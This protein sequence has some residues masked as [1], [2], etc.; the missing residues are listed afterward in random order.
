M[1]HVLSHPGP[2]R[3]GDQ[4]RAINR[5]TLA[6]ALGVVAVI[7]IASSFAIN[8]ISLVESTQVKARVLAENAGA[9][10]MFNDAASARDLLESL[11]FSQDDHGTAIYDARGRRFAQHVTAGDDLPVALASPQ[12]PVRYAIEHITLIQPIVHD[13]ERIGDLYLMVGMNALYREGV[14]QALITLI[15]AALAMAIA[16][17]LTRRLNVSVL[18]PLHALSGVMER[19]SERKDYSVRAEPAGIREMNMLADGFNA[20]LEQIQT[21]DR[22][23][24]DH[25]DHLEEMVVQRTVELTLAKEAAEAASR[26]KSDFLATMSHEIRTPMNGVLGMNELLLGSALAPQQ[27]VWAESVQRSGQHLLGV[28]NDILDFSKIE[29]GHMEL[30]AVDFDLTELVEDA[31]AMFAH[32]ADGKGLELACQFVPPDAALGVRGDPFRLRQIVVNLIGNAIK[33]TEEG[34]IVVRVAGR[35]EADGEA[36][37]SLCV[38][39]TGIGIEAAAQARIF[40]HFSQADGS[41]TR[42]F[43]GTGLG[44]AICKRLTELMGGRIRVE[45]VPGKGSKFC[46]DLR[47]PRA[48]SLSAAA[49]EPVEVEGVR[50][51][52]V[53]DNQTNRDILQ[54]QLEG[55]RMRVTCAENGDAALHA[56]ETAAHAGVPFDL[57]ILDMHMPK[58][59][60]MQLARAIHEREELATTRLMVLTST[61]THADRQAREAVGILRH[62]NKPIR[63]TDLY[64]VV[65]SVLAA[66][67]PLPECGAT[68]AGAEHAAL[69]GR[70]LLVEDNPVNQQVAQAMLARLGVPVEVADDGSQAVE[71]VRAADYDLILMDCQMPVMDGYEATAAIRRLHEGSGKRVPIVALTANA[72]Q[73]DRQKCAAAGMDDFLSKPYSLAELRAVLARWLPAAFA[74]PT[75][76][77]PTEG[78]DARDAA[79][80]APSINR[81]VLESLRE[82]DPAGGMGLAHTIMRTFLDSSRERVA[83]M[84]QAIAAGDGV[85][86]GQAAH[87]L[88][89]SA[90][91]VGAETLS[92]M[93][94]ELEQL[95]REN[96][97]DEARRL[98]DEVRTAHRL[99]VSDMQALLEE[100]A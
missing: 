9:S 3:L 94:R 30:E 84:E 11:R 43:G 6:V 67:R 51:L 97:I 71:R 13:G 45:S 79:A 44:L 35:E 92:G 91:N 34:E 7:M 15:A 60:G 53:D 16:N 22:E 29:S 2:V 75:A 90:A 65:R 33:F 96:R 74:A 81:K 52:V 80:G 69:R 19:V 10:L 99:A 88:K 86:L 40:E 4:L 31:V 56:M 26:A 36:A 61:Y 42:K 24:A 98:I 64:R 72:M 82:L 63:R 73:G 87:A 28:I 38:E 20:M 21:R 48:T 46:V 76:A 25:R 12:Q 1:K 100:G 47:L 18:H 55:W 32:Q 70:V 95:G 5:T 49:H 37:I 14:W 59:D 27:R 39:D 77:V 50:V 68:S 58:M 54:Q 57:A 85:V 89:S 83:S 66:D 78:E 62:V 23:L 41:T 93:Y 8:L 17:L